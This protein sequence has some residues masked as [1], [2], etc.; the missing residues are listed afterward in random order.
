MKKKTKSTLRVKQT[1][2]ENKQRTEKL[3][4][5]DLYGK[6]GYNGEWGKFLLFFFFVGVN[7]QLK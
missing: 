3:C 4:L 5:Q 7:D 1:E 6:S 2:Y